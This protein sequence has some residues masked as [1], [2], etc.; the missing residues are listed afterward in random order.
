MSWSP[1]RRTSAPQVDVQTQSPLWDAEPA[2]EST[3]REAIAAVAT[4]VPA[5]GEVSILLTDDAAICSLNREWRGVDKP[6]N[7]LSFPARA[8]TPGVAQPLLGDIVIAYE[9][10]AREA[11][12]ER[13]PL[14]HHLAHLAVHGFLHLMG[15]DH[16]DDAQAAVMEQLE[17][18]IL[19]RL[20]IGDPY[21]A[22]ELRHETG[23]V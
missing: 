18:D 12:A 10:V 17:R 19:A 13:K 3:V 21:R 9:T 2:A 1:H 4:L 15:Y 14:H 22:D 23:G 20:E 16:Q 5:D 11:A 7:V 8:A 6:T